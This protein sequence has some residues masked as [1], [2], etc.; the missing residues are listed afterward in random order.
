MSCFITYIHVHVHVVST[1]I[2]G[3][4]QIDIMNED[5]PVKEEKKKK[6]RKK[7]KNPGAVNETVIERGPVTNTTGQSYVIKP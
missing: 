2:N 6:R 7:N 1:D 4:E 5:M 3:T